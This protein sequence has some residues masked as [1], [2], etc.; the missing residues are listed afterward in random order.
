[1]PKEQIREMKATQTAANDKNSNLTCQVI[2]TRQYYSSNNIRQGRWYN[3][4]NE[5]YGGQNRQQGSQGGQVN[6]RVNNRD[7]KMGYRRPKAIL[8]YGYCW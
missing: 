4:K 3:R 2:D 1:M 7:S 5:Q 8:K 6:R